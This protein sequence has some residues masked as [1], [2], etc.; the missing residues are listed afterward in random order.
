[1]T[2]LSTLFGKKKKKEDI[3]ISR[4]PEQPKTELHNPESAPLPS[5][6]PPTLAKEPVQKETTVWKPGD[7]ILEHYDV[8]R[9]I[10]SGGMG[11]VYITNHRNWKVKVAIK[12]PNEEMLA[13]PSLFQRVIKEA[14]AWTELGLHPNIAYC[15]FVRNI[16]EIPHIFVE[17][18]DGGNLREWIEEGRCSDLKTGLDLAIQFCHGMA[19]AHNKGMIHRDIKPG[20]ILMTKD[21][22]LKVTDFGIARVGNNEEGD[23]SLRTKDPTKT[24]GFMGTEPYASPEQLKDAHTVGPESD[25]YS[26][27]VCLWEMFLGRRPRPNAWNDDPLQDPKTLNPSLPDSF[28]I[29]LTEMVT[30][31][32]DTRIALGGLDSLK[33]RFKAI[34]QDLFHEPS[35]H[36]ELEQVDLEADGLNNR[37]VS[38]L[39][40]GKKE[41]ALRCFEEALQQ[42]VTHPEAIFNKSLIEWRDGEITDTEVL[43]RLDNCGNNPETEKEKIAELK[44]F[45]HTE[46]FNSEAA[47]EVLKEFPDKYDALFFGKDTSQIEMIRTMEGH[48]G[49][50]GSVA[51][52]PDGRYAVS[53]SGEGRIRVWELET[54]RSIRT[55]EGHGAEVKSVAITPDGRYAI[56]GS[57]DRTLRMWDLDTGQCLRTM[58]GHTNWVESVAITP[59]GQFVVSVSYDTT[60]RVWE[61]ETGRCMS[62]MEG[63]TGWVNSVEI[64]PDGRYAVSGSNDHTIRMWELETGQCLRTMKWNI[65]DV[66]SVAISPDGRYA[67]SGSGDRSIRVWELETGQSIRT[68]D[69]HSFMVLSLAITPDGRHVVSGGNDNNL[70]VWDLETGRCKRTMEGHTG[71]ILSVAITPDGRYVVAGSWDKTLQVW[72]LG[73]QKVCP[74]QYMLSIPKGFKER[75]IEED[76]LNRAVT[77][78]KEL[79]DKGNYKGSYLTLFDAWKGLAFCNREVIT[80]LYADLMRKARIGGLSF[81]YETTLLKGHTEG[82]NCV[83]ITPDGR[84]AVSGSNDYTIRVWEL[85]TGRSVRALEGHTA[86]VNSVAITP[87]G[88]YAVSG[89]WDHTLMVWELET[90]RSIRTMEG[91]TGSILSVAITPDGRY[92]VAGSWEGNI[93]LWEFETGRSIRTMEGHKDYIYSVAITPDGR[94]AVSGCMDKNLSLLELETGQ[95]IRFMEGH[96]NPVKSVAI[97]PDSRYAVSG[98]DDTTLR[99]WE[100]ETGQC[101]RTMEGHTAAVKSVAITPDGGYAVSGSSDNTIRVWRFIWDLEFPEGDGSDNGGQSS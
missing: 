56:S 10:T 72:A 41:E 34:Y 36:S 82:V 5:S 27:G 19:H 62:I 29:L 86:M 75:K 4:L 7:V 55:M 32:R 73:L 46:S 17:Y 14:E 9:V 95:A 93:R 77:K 70:R 38:Y 80:R 101:L 11:T 42:N 52:T 58:E 65:E 28:A 1:M 87:D 60:L 47:K 91:H 100:L 49:R 2:F 44:A 6:T 31:D 20:N 92:V 50:V 68:M 59:D 16:G 67:V 51:I 23:L 66:L 53:G 90:G 83:A 74:A 24:V 15:Y 45:I 71:S 43:T 30:L 88:R 54:G 35:P 98:G 94:Y 63:H 57:E 84:Y 37:G 13:H 39:E 79:H 40:L 78:A 18:V 69:E 85:E 76:V 97:T 81:C 26:F 21:G 64:T 22:T 33:E 48:T 96:T 8:E 61:L 99:I 3:P 25:V 89:C 12:S